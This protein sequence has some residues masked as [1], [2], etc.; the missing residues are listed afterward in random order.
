MA[1]VPPLA[2]EGLPP[3]DS[4]PRESQRLTRKPLVFW[5]RTKFLVLLIA[6]WFFLVWFMM[7]NNPLAGGSDAFKTQVH[8]AYWVFI[9]TTGSGA[10]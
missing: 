6:L 8:E 3:P 4:R 5:D 7:A 1:K 9:G 10:T 2:A